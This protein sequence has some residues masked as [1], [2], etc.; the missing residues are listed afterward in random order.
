MKRVD[1]KHIAYH[2]LVGLYF[3]WLPVVCVLLYM[4]INNTVAGVGISLSKIFFT[5]IVLNLITGTALYV[6]IQLFQN[7]SRTA[8]VIRYS[9]ALV[10]AISISTALFIAFKP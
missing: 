7:K 8:T 2:V 1:A 5:W 3:I 4:A 10:T 6:V 9:F